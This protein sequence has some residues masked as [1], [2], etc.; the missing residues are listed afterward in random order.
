[1]VVQLG[2]FMHGQGL[3]ATAVQKSEEFTTMV[4]MH[5]VVSKGYNCVSI[6][7]THTSYDHAIR[8][9]VTGSKLLYIDILVWK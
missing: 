4:C 2:I 9:Y 6:L 8:S 3:H 7:C 5:L 1:M